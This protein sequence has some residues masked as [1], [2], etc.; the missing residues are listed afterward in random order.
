MGAFSQFQL[1]VSK[2]DVLPGPVAE[3]CPPPA[4]WRH[5]KASELIAA[6]FAAWE[7]KGPEWEIPRTSYYYGQAGWLT[8]NWN[9]VERW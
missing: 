2:T 4:G 6:G 3:V 9:G 8:R 1:A 7:V 5:A